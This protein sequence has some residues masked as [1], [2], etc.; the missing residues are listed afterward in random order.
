MINRLRDLV[1]SIPCARCEAKPGQPC[2]TVSGKNAG[3]EHSAR[4]DPIWLAYGEGYTDAEE[5]GKR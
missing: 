1:L 3:R 5:D 2:T 4:Q